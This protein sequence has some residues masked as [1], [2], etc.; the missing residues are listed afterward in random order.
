MIT[1]I[2]Y[3][4]YFVCWCLLYGVAIFPFL[5]KF[6]YMFFTDKRI[7]KNVQY[8]DLLHQK[9]DIYLPEKIDPHKT[10]KVVVYV[11]GGIWLFGSKLTSIMF[12]KMMLDYDIILI[13]VDYRNFPFSDIENMIDDIDLAIS[14]I[15]NSLAYVY[16]EGV[17]IIG[18][19]AGAHISLLHAIRSGDD[20]IK[21]LILIGG[22]YNL[23]N[24]IEHF[25]KM[26]L[27][28]YIFSKMMK[29]ELIEHS[30]WHV[31]NDA[32]FD[33]I[34]TLVVHSDNDPCTTI[35]NAE[36]FVKKFPNVKYM[37]CYNYRHNE[38]V[39][40]SFII[41]DFKVM[42]RIVQMIYV[43]KFDSEEQHKFL[44]GRQRMIEKWL[45]LFNPF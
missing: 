22:I 28:K 15:K 34:K 25:H 35:E 18:H 14:Y 20:F 24:Q 42:K 1:H 7:I 29:G 10:Y 11:S 31:A 38:T 30:P 5:I 36:E 4:F 45:Y 39:F 2:L 44:D 32:I 37:P 9:M 27:H 40:E 41:G 13:S 19:S 17:Y 26:G 6:A 3:I 23:P 33:K 8:G 21:G 12:Y 43:D 16:Y